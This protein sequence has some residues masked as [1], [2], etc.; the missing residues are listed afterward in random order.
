MVFFLTLIVVVWFG[1]IIYKNDR[2]YKYKQLEE[3]YEHQLKENNELQEQVSF[4]NENPGKTLD[5]FHD[6]KYIQEERERRKDRK[7][8]LRTLNKEERKAFFKME[9]IFEEE[10]IK[11]QQ[12]EN[13]QLEQK[14]AEFW[15]KM[16]EEIKN[17]NKDSN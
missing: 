15:K 16:G 14:R 3:Y 11:R 12:A 9:K 5:D 10:E 6:W 17:Q 1:F 2:D 8:H 4:I 13:Q 7:K